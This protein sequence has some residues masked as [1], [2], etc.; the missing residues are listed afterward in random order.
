MTGK[1]LRFM[2]YDKKN[3]VYFPANT[4]VDSVTNK[5]YDHN[6]DLGL[7][8]KKK[9]VR[10]SGYKFRIDDYN[11][12][13]FSYILDSIK[14][15]KKETGKLFLLRLLGK[16]NKKYILINDRPEKA[17]DNGEA[18]FRYICSERKDL[19]KKTYYVISKKSDDYKRVKKIGKVVNMNGLK[20]KILFLNAKYI[21]SSHNHKL[22]YNAFDL[23]EKKYYS[24]LFNYTYVWLQH[25]ITQN[26]IE[27]AGNRLNTKADY[28]IAATNDEYNQF[29]TRPYFYDKSHILLTGFARFDLLNDN[30]ENI[31][32]VCPTWRMNL[33]G[34]FSSDGINTP[35]E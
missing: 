26:N 30:S 9:I 4:L 20:H 21:Y 19:K 12:S 15:L 11:K 34:P 29:I 2:I 5:L 23:E 6:M 3:K 22:F 7:R 8:N 17:G 31:I 24:D 18:L 33:V 1:V 25:G 13:Q 27:I 32:S 35:L 28:I 16:R 10:F 14:S